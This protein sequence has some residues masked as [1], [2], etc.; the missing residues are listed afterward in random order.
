MSKGFKMSVYNIDFET[1]SHCN[2]PKE[3]AYNYATD[4]TTDVICMAYARDDDEPEI[5]FPGL[6]FPGALADHITSGGILTAWN[7]TFERLVWKFVLGPDY[8]AP[9]PEL[10]QWQCSAFASR[11]NNT[12]GALG[13][14]ARCLNVESQKETRGK[15]LI[16]LLC[17]PLADGS[18]FEDPELL[19]EMYAYCLQDVRAERAVL[20]QLR[21]PTPDEWQ[22]FFVNERINDR[23]VRIDRSL[24]E[25]AQT[26]AEAE[27]LDLEAKIEELTEGEITKARGEKLKFWVIDRLSED[28]KQLLVKFRAGVEMLSLDKY[29]RGRLLS[30][31]RLDPIVRQVVEASDFAQRSSVSKFKSM[32]EF[33]DPEDDRARGVFMANGAAASGRYSSRSVQ[34]HNFPRAVM[35]DPAAVRKDF[36]AE[37]EAVDIAES[38][39]LPIMALLSKMLRSALIPAAGHKFVGADWSA[40]EGRVAP[41]L[42]DNAAGLDKLQLYKDKIDTYI[43]AAAAIY[44][45]KPDEITPAQRQVGKV[46]ELSL[47][48]GGGAT[49]FAGMARGY[50]VTV[51]ED[52]SEA[53]KKAWRLSNPWAPGM[54]A[55][56]QA[57][58]FAAI[59]SP[60]TRRQAGRVSYFTVPD[61][62]CGG[63]TLFCEL[64]SKRLLTYPDVRIEMKM[65]P[66]G[67]EAP[68]ITCT[69]AAWTPKTG[70]TTWPRSGLYGGLLF[71]N[72]V[73]AVAADLLREALAEAD[74]LKLAVVL[75]V[76]D[77][78]IIEAADADVEAVSSQLSEIMLTPPEWAVGLPLEAEVE[79][80]E[81]FGK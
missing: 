8:D 45:V 51:S 56:C 30:L 7:S 32:C 78:I 75:H 27:K 60:G 13:N 31:E 52:E 17:L 67:D 11:C 54:W 33:S 36:M 22:D 39:Q 72:I 20:A 1:R 69:R 35:S 55:E 42:A 38:Y 70:E 3:G 4:L 50:G 74:Y 41:W 58:A 81:R 14:A 48:F 25:A 12:P 23:G 37:A 46:A 53:I 19:Q 43:V 66:W 5:W 40:I 64:P 71:E 44:G 77:E 28:Q 80:N 26:Y 59:R 62:I 79:I 49:A 18:F 6:E 73:Q 16:R 65:M 24:A 29:N 63:L 10:E 21:P 61:I 57:A 68:T 9:V 76:H 47:Q 15:Q 34:C 2:L